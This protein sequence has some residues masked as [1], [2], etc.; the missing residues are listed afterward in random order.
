MAEVR[1]FRAFRYDLGRVGNLGNLIA[2]AEL[3]TRLADRSQTE[4]LLRRSSFNVAHCLPD[5]LSGVSSTDQARQAGFLLRDWRADE[6][7]VQDSARSLYVCHQ[8][9]QLHGEKHT[10]RGLLARVRLE[11]LQS[12]RINLIE[13]VSPADIEDALNRLRVT[14]FNIRPVLGLYPD[15]QGKVADALDQA[16]GRALPYQA[17]MPEGAT[18]RLWPVHAQQEISTVIGMLGPKPLILAA[19]TADYHAALRYRQEYQALGELADEEAAPHFVLMLLVGINDPGL[20]FL[21]GHYEFM[22]I[23]P[24]QAVEI[25]QLLHEHFEVVP[26][27]QGEPACEEIRELLEQE[28]DQGLF[29]LRSAD[30]VWQLAR[31]KSTESMTKLLP[32]RGTAY[33]ELGDTIRQHLIQNHLLIPKLGRQPVIQQVP[34]LEK[35]PSS[36]SGLT[37]LVP[38][39]D[40]LMLENLIGEKERLEIPLALD[41]VRQAGLLFHSLRFQ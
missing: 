30:D 41:P 9:C 2:P 19:G 20:H 26:V 36:H 27:G 1:A 15:P 22:G 39:V 28:M 32:E 23:P 24:L 29:G 4:A 14:H 33:R 5:P 35:Q 21:P 3:S 38:P 40:P 25:A 11:S 7:L 18:T 12:G 13:P 34:W 37:L 8:E 31:L 6:I 16:V 17:S 10:C